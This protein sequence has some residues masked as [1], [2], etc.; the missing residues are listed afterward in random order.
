MEVLQAVASLLS[1]VF[2]VLE[3]YAVRRTGYYNDINIVG[4]PILL[5]RTNRFSHTSRKTF[6]NFYVQF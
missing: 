4:P 2:F 3:T 5:A 1:C 6:G